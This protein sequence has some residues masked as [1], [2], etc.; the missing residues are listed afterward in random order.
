MQKQANRIRLDIVSSS[1]SEDGAQYSNGEINAELLAQLRHLPGRRT[2]W[3]AKIGENKVLLKI[4]HKHAKQTR[5]AEAEWENALRLA[6]ADLSVPA[7]LFYA[8]N[9]QGEIAVGFE[10]IEGSQTLDHYLDIIGDA[11][12]VLVQLFELHAHQHNNG[13]YQAD[14]HLG[15]Y[16]CKDGII[17]MLDAG[18]CVFHDGW[19]PDEDR[20]NNLAMLVANIPLPFRRYLEGALARYLELCKSGVEGESFAGELKAAIPAAIHTRLW[21]YYKKTRRSCTEFEREN[22]Y[23]KTWL[24]C[25]DLPAELKSKLLDDPDQFFADK[26]L[27]KDGNTCTVVEVNSDGKK[28]VLKRYNKKPLGYRLTHL[29]ITPRALRS[30]TS[31]HVLNL[32]G[33][34]TPRPLACL[35]LKSASLMDRAYLLMEKVSGVPLHEVE[36]GRITAAGSRIPAA[37]ARRWRELNTISAT[38]GDMK[39][40]N[41]IVDAQGHLALIDL[42]GLKFD[43][44]PREHERRRLKDMERF[45]RNW[46][47]QPELAD[48]FIEALSKEA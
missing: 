38:H 19:L 8:E 44:S 24:A 4:Y 39:A 16:L 20:L 30:W 11:E 28:Y 32:F 31:G 47:D 41:F 37:F 48:A 46:K 15:N 27:L 21:K 25:R 10:L 13:C 3:Q 36:G 9:D 45:M 22:G 14:D 2:V 7:P 23:G 35:L 42:D 12:K 29:L 17:Y 6:A 5:D 1:S 18:S 33:I 43:R 34:R 40:S 26:A